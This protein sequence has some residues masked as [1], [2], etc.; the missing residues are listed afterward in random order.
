MRMKGA[1]Y[2][3]S[4]SLVLASLQGFISG[5]TVFFFTVYVFFLQLMYEILLQENAS[6]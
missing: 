5:F 2:G 3:L 1:I 4:L 6:D